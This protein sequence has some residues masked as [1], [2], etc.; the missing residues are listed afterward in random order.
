MQTL[1]T[2]VILAAGM[3]TRLRDIFKNKPKGL[4]EIGGK[5]LIMESLRRITVGGI[6]D[7]IMVTGYSS[8]H[9]KQALSKEYP[10]IRYVPNRE[11][12]STGSM[13]SLF[14]V[15]NLVTSDFLLLESDLL[16]EDRC[17]SALMDSKNKTE[18][19]ISGKT[20][21]GDEVYVYGE[22]NRVSRINKAK[23]E[24][25][26]CQGELV[27]ISKLD[28][29]FF[30]QLCQYYETNLPKLKNA[31]YEECISDL[32]VTQKV[33]YL[34]ILDLVWTEID[35]PDHYKRALKEIYP[36]IYGEEP[37]AL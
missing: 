6:T 12:D 15:R 17:I 10:G 21:S 18:I 11:Y 33:H 19:L 14:Q 31:H 24:T 37:A 1:K 22:N 29:S 9:Y 34:R 27:G 7:I 36:R 4:L 26:T 23:S 28:R 25:L 3:G 32:S 8:D 16:Y 5:Q 13:H 30:E 2:A 35:N 20:G